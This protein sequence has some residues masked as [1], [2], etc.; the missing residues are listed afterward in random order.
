MIRTQI[1]LTEEQSKT[2]KEL[3]ARQGKSIAELIR[4]SVDG[5]LQTQGMM[6]DEQRVQRA[7][8]VVGRFRTGDSDLA[9]EHDRYLNEAFLP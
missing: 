9:E 3:S 6:S 4:M 2:L 5:L 7:L 1:Q 8:A